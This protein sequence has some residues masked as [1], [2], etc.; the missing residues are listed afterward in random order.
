M[1]W[2]GGQW[3]VR[4][5][6]EMRMKQTKSR[7]FQLLPRCS[8][9]FKLFIWNFQVEI[10][11]SRIEW[12][13]TY[14]RTVSY[15]SIFRFSSYCSLTHTHTAKNMTF[16]V[17]YVIPLCR[18]I[19]VIVAAFNLRINQNENM[20]HLILPFGDPLLAAENVS[21][22][23][24]AVSIIALYSITDSCWLNVNAFKL[25]QRLQQIVG[26]RHPQHHYTEQKANL[27]WSICKRENA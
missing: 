25:H 12:D 2:W 14:V 13:L 4:E 1:E 18:C 23:R 21:K 9:H 24:C 22:W 6:E 11:I 20:F 27:Q 15:W 10:N 3:D 26:E 7:E 17:M 16:K 8:N 19:C 5:G